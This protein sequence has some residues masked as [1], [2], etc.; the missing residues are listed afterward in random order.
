MKKIFLTT[1]LIFIVTNNGF[2]LTLDEAIKSARENNLEIKSQE[3]SYKAAKSEK[4]KALGGFLPKASVS[5]NNGSRKTKIG[6][7]PR[8]N[9]DIDSKT[10]TAS[11]NLFDGFGS[12]FKLKEANNILSK[13]KAVKDSKM[14]QVS[15]GVIKAYLDSLRYKK[16]LELGEENLKSQK[17]LFNYIIRRFKV[18][19][20]T[21]AEIAKAKADFIKAKSDYSSYQNNFDFSKVNLGRFVE[22]DSSELADLEEVA[23]DYTQDG[24]EEQSVE[25]MVIFAIQNNPDV[26]MAKHGHRASVY[27]SKASK[28]AL[29][30][31]VN[32]N[33]EVTEQEDSLF[34]NNQTQRD[35]S[36]YL[37]VTVPI[38]TSGLNYFNI[39]STSN[40]RKSERYNY[41]SVKKKV[42]NLV[43]EYYGRQKNLEASYESAKELEKANEV[44]LLT[45]RKEERLGTRSIIELLE[46][47]QDLYKSQIEAINLY[48]DMIYNRFEL[49]SLMGEL[50]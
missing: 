43:I 2:A 38:F 39:S 36:V 37:N 11:Q 8:S 41:E 10:F 16:L 4:L 29:A 46:A 44:Y 26:R 17:N 12:T 9:N 13:E 24:Y 42:R 7:N 6:N 49:G 20:A 1:F 31:Q 25:E 48:Y 45:L 5:A 30:P 34:L 23:F 50:I 19:D 21:R 32:L 47:K 27:R 14:Q 35:R 28:S 40:S 33:F 18:K 22:I 15:L 3:Y